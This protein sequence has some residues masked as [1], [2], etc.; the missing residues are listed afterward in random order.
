MRK[1]NAVPYGECGHSA[2]GCTC[3][4]FVFDPDLTRQKDDD[5]YDR[6][7]ELKADLLR[8]RRLGIDRDE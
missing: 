5:A 4:E 7:M 8:D 2:Y 3:D 1:R 6:A